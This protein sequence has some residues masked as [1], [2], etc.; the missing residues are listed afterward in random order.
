MIIPKGRV[1]IYQKSVDLRKSYLRL[2]ALVEQE[3][4]VNPMSEDAYVFINRDKSLAKVLWWDRTG[5]CLFI[6]KL[7]SS[8]YRISDSGVL[9]ELEIKGIRMFFDGL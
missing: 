5:W 7:S 8:K 3:L 6:K 9:K 2:S 1:W 4:S